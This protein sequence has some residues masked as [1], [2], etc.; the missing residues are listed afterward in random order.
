MTAAAALVDVV[1]AQLLRHCLLGE[2]RLSGGLSGI[3]FALSELAV[4]ALIIDTGGVGIGLFDV[5]PWNTVD[6]QVFS[7]AY[8]TVSTCARPPAS[9]SPFFTHAR[10]T[11]SAPHTVAFF[12]SNDATIS[13]T[14][15]RCTCLVF[16]H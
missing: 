16:P 11:S 14:A 7:A 12:L 6:G 9:D 15:L 4:T 2:R 13:F 5:A 10:S 8:L 3:A 1:T